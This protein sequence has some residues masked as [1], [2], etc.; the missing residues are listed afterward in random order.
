MSINNT[1]NNCRFCSE[2]SQAN[3]EDPIG[4]AIA[5]EQYLI[6]EAAQPWPIP[7]WI[8]PD[9]MPQG[10]IEALN[11]IWEGG[12]TVRQLAIAPDKEYSHPGYTRVIYYRRPAKFFAQ[13]EKQEF[14][15]PHALLGSLAL[16]LLKNPEEL[17]NFN[18]YRQQTNHIREILVCNH[19]NVDAAC[20]RFGYPIYQKLRS[21]YAAA[22]NSNLRFWRCSHFG[23]HEFAPT[24][25]DL[26]QGQYWGHL[27]PEILDLL[28][29][30]N[31]SV[32]EL[33]PYYRGWG[34]LSFFEQIAEREI[35]M[36]EGWK[37][38]EYHKAG[39]VLASD[40]INQEWADVRIDFTTVDGNISSAYQAR[41]EVKGSVMTAWKSGANPTLEEVKQYRVRNLVKLAL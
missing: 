20:S 15:V 7:I 32:K 21:E 3:G 39:Q 2:I 31:G 33:Y 22:T 26:P 11:F 41:V 38:L 30:R 34:G 18:Q 9:P 10:V 35:W 28:V 29:L 36:L 6:I 24:L 17:P 27:K 5:V 1:Q 8:E 12:G 16:A 19:G 13:F 25:V 37:W 23:G 40:E 14:I 4:T